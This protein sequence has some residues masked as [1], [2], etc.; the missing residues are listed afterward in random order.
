VAASYSC[1]DGLSGPASCSGAVANG[2]NFVALPVGSKSF[3]VSASDRAG[4]AATS[5]SLYSVIYDFLG[6]FQPID[7]GAN[8]LNSVK[9]GSAVPV[10]FKLGGNAGMDVFQAGSPSSVG[11]TCSSTAVIDALEETLAASTSGLQYDAAADQYVYVW[12]TSSTWANSCRQL[13]VVLKDGK[14]VSANFK[15]K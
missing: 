8:V 3:S 15:F 11:I 13:K 12:K 7:M 5:T 14:T 4:N 2:V 9:A 10:K 6:L 1:A